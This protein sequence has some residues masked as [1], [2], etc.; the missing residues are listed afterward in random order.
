MIVALDYPR[1]RSLARL[2]RLASLTASAPM[3]T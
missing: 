2:I 3:V 1:W